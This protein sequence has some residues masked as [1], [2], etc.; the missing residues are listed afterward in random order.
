[1]CELLRFKNAGSLM[2]RRGRSGPGGGRVH[3]EDQLADV[4]AGEHRRQGIGEGA[5][6]SADD[7]LARDQATVAQQARDLGA[8][9]GIAVG[10]VGR[11][12][13]SSM[14]GTTRSCR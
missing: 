9:L 8:G 7:L 14:R 3:R 11:G 10:V 5:D 4:R 12:T 13:L 1:M 6:T 2:L